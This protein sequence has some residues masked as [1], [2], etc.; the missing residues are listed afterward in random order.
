MLGKR[1]CGLDRV[2]ALLEPHLGQGEMLVQELAGGIVVLDRK[3]RAGNAVILRGL[4][5]QGQFGFDAGVTEIA[6]TDLDRVGRESVGSH[7][8][9][10]RHGALEPFAFQ[11]R[12]E[13]PE[14]QRRVGLPLQRF[15]RQQR[16]RT[17]DRRGLLPKIN[18]G[19]ARE[20]LQQQPAFV[21]G[22]TG[23][24]NGLAFEIVDGA[25]R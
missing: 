10:H 1:A 9:V 15:L 7:D 11:F 19:A 18:A 17:I 12:A 14:G 8:L 13:V 3:A 21:D 16:R 25:D 23:N 22:A 2:V 24:R 20:R 6:D 5:D 4:F